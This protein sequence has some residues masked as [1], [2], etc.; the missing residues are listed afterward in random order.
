[1]KTALQNIVHTQ[2]LLLSKL[3]QKNVASLRDILA[4]MTNDS[5]NEQHGSC[6][7]NSTVNNTAAMFCY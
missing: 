1:M 4:Q 7:G 6:Y 5:T 2:A 3:I